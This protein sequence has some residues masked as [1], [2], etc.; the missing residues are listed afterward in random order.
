MPSSATH[1]YIALDVYEKLNN[2]IKKTINYNIDDYKAYSQ[3]MDVFYFYSIL[4]IFNIKSFEVKKFGSYTHKNKTNKLLINLINEIKKTQDNSCFL[5][6]IGLVT[7][8]ISDSTIHPFINYQSKSISLDNLYDNHFFLESYIDNY[9]I[10]KKENN[11][12]YYKF[13]VYDFCFNVTYNKNIENMLNKVFKD[14]FNKNNYGIYYY[15]SLKEIKRFFK[16]F[17]HDEYK[18]KKY[19][20]LTINPLVKKIFRSIKY[21]SYNFDIS[22]YEKYLNLNHDTWYNI[23]NKKI[24]SNDSFFDLYDKVVIKTVYIINEL[25]EYIYFNKDIDLEKLLENRSYSTGLIIN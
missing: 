4:N 14:T 16:L 21:L 24:V 20:Y 5:F 23:Y 17:R 22:N 6:L 1:A 12:E 13:K 3:G 8:Y 25:Y 2:K 9:I 15:K 10:L 11:E 7:H 18:I 19:L